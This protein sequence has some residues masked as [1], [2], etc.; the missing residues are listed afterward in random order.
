MRLIDWPMIDME[1]PTKTT[2]IEAH[3]IRGRLEA[4]GIPA[5]I[6]FEHHIWENWTLSNALGGVRVQVITSKKEEVIDVISSIEHGKYQKELE[7]Q[8]ECTDKNLCSACNS[9][10]ATNVNWSWKLAFL[11]LFILTI[12]VPFFQ[13]QLKC[14]KCNHSWKTYWS[15]YPVFVKAFTV[16][17]F[18]SFLLILLALWYFWCRLNCP[19]A[20]FI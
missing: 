20:R 8:I 5:F 14:V 3:I 7:D 11:S 17:F 15:V 10:I 18:C 4:E 12:P 13:N 6:A 16:V 2:A 19:I 1:L 9:S